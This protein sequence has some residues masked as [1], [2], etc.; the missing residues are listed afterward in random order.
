VDVE[1][2][3]KENPFGTTVAHGNLSLSLIDG[4]AST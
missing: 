1:R 3:E 2:A 4:C